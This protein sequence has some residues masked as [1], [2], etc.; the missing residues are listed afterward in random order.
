MG[1]EEW[2]GGWPDDLSTTRSGP[3]T[4]HQ[5][6]P[7][8]S[9]SS[10]DRPHFCMCRRKSNCFTVVLQDVCELGEV[11]RKL[12]RRWLL[13]FLNT[14]F[15]HLLGLLSVLCGSFRRDM[16][17]AYGSIN[18]FNL[19]SNMIDRVLKPP[20]C[21]WIVFFVLYPLGFRCDFTLNMHFTCVCLSCQHAL[22][23]KC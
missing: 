7:A 6:L 9:S 12:H 19:M 16:T 22:Q 18:R 4:H 1:N 23:I 15:T 5:H 13:C 17:W 10:I 8:L 20:F 2:V 3:T 11:E 21:I 14:Q